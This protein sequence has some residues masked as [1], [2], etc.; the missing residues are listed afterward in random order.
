MPSAWWRTIEHAMTPAWPM[1]ERFPSRTQRSRAGGASRIGRVEPREVS[2]RM[3]PRPASFPSHMPRDVNGHTSTDRLLETA[4][5]GA[6]V[7]IMT[8]SHALDLAVTA[9]ALLAARCACV[10][11]ISGATKCARSSGTVRQIGSGD[12][13]LTHLICPVGLTEIHDKPPGAM[14]AAIAQL[15]IRRDTAAAATSPKFAAIVP[16]GAP[17]A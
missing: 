12:A 8:H 13:D 9:A 5:E 11:L 3:V 2:A 6:F 17:H 16:S 14:A 15:L 10:G 7:A 4:P 1:T